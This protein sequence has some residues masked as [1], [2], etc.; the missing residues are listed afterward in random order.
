MWSVGRHWIILDIP[1]YYFTV[2][3]R[4]CYVMLN[5]AISWPMVQQEKVTTVTFASQL[6]SLSEKK[7]VVK[8]DLLKFRN[9]SWALTANHNNCK[10]VNTRLAA[11]YQQ[12]K[13]DFSMYGFLKRSSVQPSKLN[14]PGV[15]NVKVK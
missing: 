6:L 4:G 10:L 13:N 12:T 5:C 2:H 15:W 7:F 9:S 8:L 11:F 3:Q 1:R 14:Y